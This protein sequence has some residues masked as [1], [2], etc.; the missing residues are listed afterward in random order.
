MSVQ[1]DVR[2]LT[3]KF[4]GLHTHL[5]AIILLVGQKLSSYLIA[6]HNT[7]PFLGNSGEC[8]RSGL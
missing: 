8:T 7:N 5:R 4:P 3:D 2:L 1:D 6:V